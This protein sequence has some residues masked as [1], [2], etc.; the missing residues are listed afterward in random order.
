MFIVRDSSKMSTLR[1]LLMEYFF[2][3]NEGDNDPLSGLEID[4]M[5]DYLE[6]ARGERGL[7]LAFLFACENGVS[8]FPCT[9]EIMVSSSIFFFGPFIIDGL[10][11]FLGDPLLG[12]FDFLILMISVTFFGEPSF[13]T[14]S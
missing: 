7:V 2:D 10:K 1:L 14:C 9:P 11:V 6:A 8:C 13:I 4:L 3:F 5:F 12:D